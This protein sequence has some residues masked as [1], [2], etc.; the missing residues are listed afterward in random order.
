MGIRYEM[1]GKLDLAKDNDKRKCFEDLKF[2]A[3]EKG[4]DGK[5]RKND[6]TSRTL[7]LTVK[8]GDDFFNLR[9]KGNL[10]GNENT[11]LI[12]SLK[13][14]ADGTYEGV[15]F[16]YKDREKHTK[17]L[18]EFKKLVF[19]HGDERHEFATEYEFA[20]FIH[21]TLSGG[22]LKDKIFKIVGEIE[23]SEYNDKVYTN[24]NINRIYV[25]KD[26]VEQTATANVDLMLTVDSIDDSR[27][28]D[29]GI[30][31]VSGYVPQ[32]D[33]KKKGDKG[34]FQL[35]EYP[36]NIDEEKREKKFELISRLLKFEEGE[37][38]K[39]GFKVDLISRV[40]EVD[41]DESMLSDEDKE[42]IEFGVMTLSDFKDKYGSG[43]GGYVS[44]MQI[45]NVSSLYKNGCIPTELSLANLLSSGV[46]V[47]KEP[48]L[49]L[50]GS[51]TDDELDDMDI[52]A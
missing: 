11:A 37:L 5:P 31:T 42:L 20:M 12:K 17:D 4:G 46:E 35:L 16:K 38:A 1:V 2:K 3:G 7:R 32:Y 40:E 33:G 47:T 36:L 44:K 24:Y 39:I 23:F 34:Y 19:V 50:E 14:K 51:L 25:I 9:I 10:F 30:F 26:D 43:K 41:F 49:N 45:S 8:S 15:E 27:V 6:F 52:F 28:V 21:E 48:E 13:K 29:E 18:A 22:E